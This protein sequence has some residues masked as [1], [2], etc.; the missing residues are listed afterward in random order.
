MAAPH[1]ARVI[2]W[3][4]NPGQFEAYTKYLRERVGESDFDIL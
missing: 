4:A 2:Y 1:C 3:R